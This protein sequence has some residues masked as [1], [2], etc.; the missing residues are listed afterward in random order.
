MTS[1][2]R[3]PFLLRAAIAAAGVLA[4]GCATIGVGDRGREGLAP[5]LS[6]APISRAEE[7]A[8]RAAY[9]EGLAAVDVNDHETALRHFSRVVDE[10]P[11]SRWSGM[12]LYWQGRTRYQ[13]GDAQ[14]AETSLER[15]LGLS[16][17]VPFRESA[18]LLLANSRY[19]QREFGAALDAA[20][21]LETAAGDRLA[22]FLDLSRDLLRQLPRPA[23]EGAVG[24]VPPR[25]FLAPF[26]LQAS[27]WAYS[28]GDTTRAHDLARRVLAFNSLP[29]SV[30]SEARALAGPGGSDPATLTRPRLGFL[31]P[32]EGRFADVTAEIERGIQIA[33]EDLEGTQEIELVT[34]PTF[35]DA[36]STA[37]VIRALARGDRV[38]AILGPVVSEVAR[39]AAEVARE[40]GVAMVSPTATD[41]RLL[42]IDPRIY[43]VNALDG[44]IGHTMGMYAVRSLEL[45]RIAILARDDAYG[46][47]Q[48][49]AFEQAV[50]SAGGR[51]VLRRP[52]RPGETDFTDHLQAVVQNASQAVFI[53]TNRPSEALRA[54]NQM[55]FYELGSVLPLG[56]DAWND[57]EFQGQGRRFARG[58]FADTFSRDPRVT[59]WDSFSERYEALFGAEPPNRI[60]AWG[61]DAARLALERLSGTGPSLATAEPYRGASAYFRFGPE[62]VR[63]AVVIHRIEGG[64]PVAVEW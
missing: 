16:P 19:E 3:T 17:S 46:R 49:D 34:R 8:A 59:R 25:D 47:I 44:S 60:P 64:R 28:A 52:F 18:I 21:R 26:Y 7:E 51:V 54:L 12:S 14:G 50:R 31:A 9:E 22:E 23:V 43:S 5:P 32:T 42:G 4:L 10:Y 57:A 58:Y 37:E 13:V 56:T 53:A 1:R 2:G 29:G 48:A 45:Q 62:G 38:R 61:Y 40:E 11:A 41:A 33:L 20:M 30:L 63:R 15:Y 6:G 27:R 39:A 35:A 24:A 55:A 36:D